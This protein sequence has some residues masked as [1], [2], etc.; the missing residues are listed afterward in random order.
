MCGDGRGFKVV[1]AV[2]QLL[3]DWATGRADAGRLRCW[4][5]QLL[6]FLPIAN[7]AALTGV[8]NPNFSLCQEREAAFARDEMAPR[9]WRGCA[10]GPYK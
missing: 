10:I 2:L 3:G 6:P 5:R 8:A 7:N 9:N 4:M 1:P